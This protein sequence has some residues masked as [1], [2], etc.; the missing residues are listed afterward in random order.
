MAGNRSR[1]A[2]LNPR[3]LD[4]GVRAEVERIRMVDTHEHL[5][6]E[7]VRLAQPVNLTRFFMYYA[8]DEVAT[9]GMTPD[10]ETL[11]WKDGVSGEEQWRAIRRAWPLA[12]HSGFCRA[13]TLAI[14]E[15]YGIDDLR[16]DTI[17]PL[18]KAIE[19]RNKPGVLNW[20]L[21][22][23]ANLECCLVNATDPG[24]LAR[25]TGT[26]GLFLFDLAVSPFCDNKLDLAPY[27]KASGVAAP[28]LKDW[29][30]LIDWYFTRWGS[31][32]VAIKNVAAY[33]RVCKYDDVPEADAAPLY[34]KWLVRKEETTPAERK[35]VQDHMFHACIRRAQDLDLPVK[36]HTGY[37]AG[38]NYMDMSL[39]QVKDLQNLFR[40]YP[41]ARFDVFHIGYPEWTDV[42]ALTKHY[43]N[44]YANLCWA[45]VIDPEASLAFCRHALAALPLN[46]ILAF[47]ADYGFADMVPG[48][49]RIARD[50]VALV[51]S[52]AVK[53]GRLT[54]ADAK[55]AA[56][57]W[58]RD[59][60]MELY[61]IDARRAAQAAGQ[62]AVLP[63]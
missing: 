2:W 46:K 22:D 36:I 16:D 39:F 32:V 12:K 38:H 20:I 18:L 41:K 48:H 60:A 7:A 51:L 34:E 50:G 23:K 47:G 52:D 11:F 13:I 14:K 30:H 17:K 27:E 8:F 26:P 45:W 5:D 28:T 25:R 19:K 3:A 44:V 53:Q 58:L 24:D 57:R 49:A 31:Q 10:E 33:W 4:P 61:R 54:R 55:F 43:A 56:R 42:L 29:N 35:A 37:H 6:E 21:R 40:Q 62:P 1:A 63:S 59:N 9:A 15:L